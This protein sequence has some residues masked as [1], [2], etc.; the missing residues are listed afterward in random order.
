VT[1]HPIDFFFLLLGIVVEALFWYGISD[2]AAAA[3]NISK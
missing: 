1:V 3:D 2:P